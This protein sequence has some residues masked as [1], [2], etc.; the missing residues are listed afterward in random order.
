ML[1]ER[2]KMGLRQKAASSRT[3]AKCFPVFFEGEPHYKT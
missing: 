2:L 3:E 1:A